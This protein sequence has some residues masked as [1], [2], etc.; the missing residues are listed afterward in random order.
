MISV[1]DYTFAMNPND[2]NL[3]LKQ[4]KVRVRVRRVRVRAVYKQIRVFIKLRLIVK[5]SLFLTKSSSVV[6]VTSF[7][8]QF[9]KHY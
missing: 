3:Y 9:V 8:A 1:F 2:Q 7:N 5:L 6:T 4:V